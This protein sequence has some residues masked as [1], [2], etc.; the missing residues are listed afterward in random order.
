M[1]YICE[2]LCN[3]WITQF[4]RHW[5]KFSKYGFIPK[6]VVKYT[7]AKWLIDLEKIYSQKQDNL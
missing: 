5:M 4:P 7:N 3:R 2:T 6:R 1:N